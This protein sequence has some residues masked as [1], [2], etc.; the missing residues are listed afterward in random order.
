VQ[1]VQIRACGDLPDRKPPQGLVRMG[2][3]SDQHPGVY[4]VSRAEKA[5]GH[6]GGVI[7]IDGCVSRQSG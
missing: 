5:R 3:Q 1:Q 7:V 2:E 4:V 6:D